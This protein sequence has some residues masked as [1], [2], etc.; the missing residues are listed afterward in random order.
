MIR[1]KDKLISVCND[2][3]TLHAAMSIGS[4]TRH[5]SLGSY[6]FSAVSRRLHDRP[7]TGKTLMPKSSAM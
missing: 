5:K 1:V 4:F 6:S 7:K 3:D 2:S